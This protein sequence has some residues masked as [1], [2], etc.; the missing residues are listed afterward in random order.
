M[1][2]TDKK[3]LIENACTKGAEV[4]LI[5]HDP[6]NGREMTKS[7][8][9]RACHDKSFEMLERFDGHVEYSDSLLEFA[10]VSFRGGL[11]K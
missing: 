2:M 6:R 4:I 9:V 5:F 1:E 8:Y 3:R 10:T 11:V 7:G